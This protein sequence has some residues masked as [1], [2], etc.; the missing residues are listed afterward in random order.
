MTSWQRCRSASYAAAFLLLV[1][2][3]ARAQELEPRA[4]GIA[5][6]GTTI[7]LTSIGGSKGGILFDPSIAVADVE[8]D[9][10]ILTAGFGY[11]FG[12]GGRQARV[13]VV[14]PF[15]SGEITGTVGGVRQQQDL[16]GLAD[17]RIRFSIG[18][19]GA[20]ARSAAE[21]A[22]APRQLAMGVAVTMMPPLGQYDP[23][24]VANLGYHRWAFKPEIG[25]T[26]PVGR[27]TL[28]GAAGVWFFT[29]NASYGASRARKEQDAML[30]LQG[31]IVYAVTN[32]IWTAFDATGFAGGET[33]VDRIVNP[34]E[35]R[36]ARLGATLSMPLAKQQSLKVTY[37]TGAT[38]RRGS[39]FDS[40][41]VTWQ[42]VTF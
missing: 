16:R 24:Q 36:N 1:T 41:N 5:P 26:R 29:D 13:L 33:R 18:L 22:S 25:I 9:L 21:I 12:I 31:H 7:V 32:R 42:L 28:E 37:S 2:A 14:V 27:F 15:A 20:A 17:P 38:T 19:R 39:D 23:L 30:S 34:D 8:A 35:Q 10:A 3:A 11:T 40:F 4:Y 6:V